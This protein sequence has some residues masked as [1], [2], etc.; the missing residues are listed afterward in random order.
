M[1]HGLLDGYP[2]LVEKKEEVVAQ[3]KWTVLI[4]N[5]RIVL[6]TSSAFDAAKFESDKSVT[7][8]DLKALLAVDLDTFS[9]KKK[10]VAKKQ[11]EAAPKQE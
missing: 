8:A 7:D 6:L 4:S 11:E 2:V 3:F 5:K 10:D 1:T 9:K